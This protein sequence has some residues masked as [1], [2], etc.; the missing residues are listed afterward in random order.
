MRVVMN[1]CPCRR[2]AG[3]GD[4]ASDLT[5]LGAYAAKIATAYFSNP[6]VI[7]DIASK[8]KQLSTKAF[9]IFMVTLLNDAAQ[10]KTTLGD[11]YNAY[12]GALYVDNPDDSWKC[13][14]ASVSTAV[15]TA[16]ASLVTQ[17]GSVDPS[18][19][20]LIH[21]MACLMAENGDSVG[22]S[23]QRAMK[24]YSYL[25]KPGK[26][27]SATYVTFDPSAM[28]KSTKKETTAWG[29]YVELDTETLKK[30]KTKVAKKSDDSSGLV[31]AAGVGLG[32]AALW[33]WVL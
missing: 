6:S 8:A 31:T 2:N 10:G 28:P 26:T 32:L 14:N 29:T 12:L 22:N 9:E 16:L 11:I 15:Q 23:V 27:F 3:L 25:L 17:G 33:K 21:Q 1:D 13:V 24:A 20:F 19:P 30:T 4:Y 5:A 18:A 7:S